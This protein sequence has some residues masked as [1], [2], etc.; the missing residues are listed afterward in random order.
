M[1]LY[2]HRCFQIFLG[3]EVILMVLGRIHTSF[4]VYASF[5]LKVKWRDQSWRLEI[6]VEA[7]LRYTLNLKH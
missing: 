2:L 7:S 5:A 4:Q 1:L 3:I 6:Y